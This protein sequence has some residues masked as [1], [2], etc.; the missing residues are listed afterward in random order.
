MSHKDK[1]NSRNG[2]GNV[3]GGQRID[4]SPFLLAR[5]FDFLEGQML[6]QGNFLQMGKRQY[7]CPAYQLVE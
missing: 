5:H 4:L 3:V 2:R 6:R 7:T 1:F